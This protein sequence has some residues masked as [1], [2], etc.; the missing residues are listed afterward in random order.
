MRSSSALLFLCAL[1]V[2]GAPIARAQSAAENA[3]PEEGSDVP[4]APV[5]GE[6]TAEAEGP[7]SSAE[8]E[9]AAAEASDDEDA[10]AEASSDDAEEA[11]EPAPAPPSAELAVPPS[12]VE[13]GGMPSPGELSERLSAGMET[14]DGVDTW[15]EPVPVFALDGYMRMRGE[16]MDTFWLGRRSLSELDSDV[17]E[18]E[19]LGPDP[20]TRYRPLESDD[21]LSACKSGADCGADTLQNA[22]LRLRVSPILNLTEDVRVRATFDVLDNV[23]AGQAPQSFYGSGYS[24]TFSDTL[25]PTGGAYADTTGNGFL[26][27]S[28]VARRA[29][30]EVRNR[31]LGELHFGRM[32]HHWGL[33]MRYNAGNGLDHDYSTDFDRVMVVTKL[34]GLY[35]TAAYD[36]LGEGGVAQSLF[37]NTDREVSLDYSRPYYDGSQVDD[38]DQ[39]TFSVYRR[40]S[41]EDAQ[42][43]LLAGEAVFNAG[44]HLEWRKQAARYVITTDGEGD[45]E[46][47]AFNRYVPDLWVQLLLP[48]IRLEAEAAWVLGKMTAVEEGTSTDLS[49]NQIGL[50]LESEFRFLDERLAL[51]LYGGFASGDEDVEGLSADAD[52]INQLG[53]E[54]DNVTTY[55]FH[56]SYQVDM[57]LWRNLMRQVSGAYY[58]KPGISYDFVRTDFGELF[59]MRMDVIWS[60]A[61]SF[62]QTWGNNPN[63]G[64][65]FN[66]QLYWRSEDGA[67]PDDG[68]HVMVQYGALFPMAGLGYPDDYDSD[69]DDID[70]KVAQ[71]LRAV[72]G[73][74]F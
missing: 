38:L 39:F 45:L 73:V 16:L 46:R 7:E 41:D 52:F 4:S 28:I 18:L 3:P 9:D 42:K 65:E 74:K 31:D 53:G 30:A 25:S 33:G 55:S 68:Y 44:L 66:A 54:D 13:A 17:S 19:G 71:Q 56:P 21:E 36:F 32:P 48:G 24:S 37:A 60:R 23:V 72:L 12:A 69:L 14:Y 22:N 51:Y 57:I 67:E 49:L 15:T 6:T 43:A 61:S 26:G 34:A 2:G 40:S 63:L 59:G 11:V 58:I 62:L 8:D 50:A 10:A 1:V 5:E 64:V 47:V 70:L 29:W 20:F 27:S 35:F